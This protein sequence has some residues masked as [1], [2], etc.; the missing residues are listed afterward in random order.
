MTTVDDAFV[1][2]F[3]AV[4]DADARILILG[5]MPGKASLHAAEY[6]AHPRNAFW[7]IIQELFAIDRQADYTTRLRLLRRQGIALWDVLQ[8][9]QRSSSLDSDIRSEGSISNDLATFLNMHPHI[10]HLFFN[11]S[12]AA[13][14][15]RQYQRRL[16]TS[17]DRAGSGVGKDSNVRSSSGNGI[18]S[19]SGDISCL[20][21]PSTSAANATRSFAQKLAAWQAVKTVLEMAADDKCKQSHRHVQI[22]DK[23]W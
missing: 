6:Y 13:Q 16:C 19:N 3:P 15:Y 11:G 12:K 2:G 10:R 1:Q 22:T 7:P 8:R 5:S 17:V 23:T 9:C 20:R 4:A 21:L 14:L 18:S